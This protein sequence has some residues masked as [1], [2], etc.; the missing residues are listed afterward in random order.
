MNK[1]RSSAAAKKQK[2]HDIEEPDFPTA[3][4]F[5][6]GRSQAVRLPKEF[7]F[8]GDEIGV[9]RIGNAVLLYPLDAPW[10]VFFEGAEELSSLPPI[11]RHQD[12]PKRKIS[13]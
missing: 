10:S 11:E 1:R 2:N 12:Q 13:K 5:L 4:L 3:K 9:G 8:E 6:N 7:R